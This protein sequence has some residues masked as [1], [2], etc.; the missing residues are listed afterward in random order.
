MLLEEF[1]KAGRSE[2]VAALR[3]CL[4][5]P[6]WIDEIA[7]ARPFSSTHDLILS[8]RRAASPFTPGEVESALVHHPRIGERAAGNSSEA[9]FSRDE[10]EALGAASAAV[11]TALSKGNRNYE[12]KFGQVF[13]IR[14]AGR[15]NEEILGALQE[16]IS[17]TAGEEDR[18]VQQQ[19]REIAVHRLEGMISE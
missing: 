19:L 17:N 5:I 12:D 16:R 10:Q 13:L 8:A 3:P 2:V 15:S 4:D 11:I 6:R 1:N 18:V 14:A 7:D 9:Q